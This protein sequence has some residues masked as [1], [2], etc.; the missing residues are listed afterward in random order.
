MCYVLDV[1]SDVDH[2][3]ATIANRGD[4][5]IGGFSAGAYGA[6]N[7]AL[8]NLGVFGN[9][10]SWSGYYL[11]TRSGVF[12]HASRPTLASNS[13]LDYVRELRPRARRRSAPG[14]PVRR[15]RRRRQSPAAS[16]WR[17]RWPTRGAG[18]SYALYRGGHDWQLWYAQLDQMLMLASRDVSRPLRAGRDAPSLTPGVVPIPHG[19]GQ[20][21]SPPP[22]ARPP[23]PAPAPLAAA[24][25]VGLRPAGRAPAASRAAAGVRARIATVARRRDGR[26]SVSAS[27]SA[28]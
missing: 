26:G 21:P 5:V 28:A 18:V 11:E 10:Q 6:T 4:R 15:P 16:R 12:A 3:F 19:D 20:S 17:R 23:T 13:P 1:V 2:R 7:I 14:V 27:C 24:A 8:H 22:A 25:P 9:L